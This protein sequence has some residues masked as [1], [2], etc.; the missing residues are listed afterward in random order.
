MKLVG[1]HHSGYG[2]PAGDRIQ[3][4]LIHPEP[5]DIQKHFCSVIFKKLQ[6]SGGMIVFPYIIGDSQ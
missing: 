2:I 6:I 5:A 4:C 1:S 3:L